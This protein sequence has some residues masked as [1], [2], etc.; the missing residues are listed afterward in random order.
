MNISQWFQRNGDLVST[1]VLFFTLMV[2]IK[3]TWETY[4][5]RKATVNHNELILKPYITAHIESD[6]L[7]LINVGNG[8][9]INVSIEDFIVSGIS[10][11]ELGFEN[12]R[13]KISFDIPKNFVESHQ[14]LKFGFNAESENAEFNAFIEEE[15]I[16]YFGFPYF[17]HGVQEYMIRIHYEDIIQQ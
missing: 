7:S 13:M 8:S 10:I 11:S 2:L 17:R 12:E 16:R 4:K 9:A 14:K 5:L 1:I 15:S 6:N 3:Y